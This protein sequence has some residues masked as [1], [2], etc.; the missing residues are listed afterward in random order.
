M[1]CDFV[2]MKKPCSYDL[3][4]FEDAMGIYLNKKSGEEVRK[5][6]VLYTI[7]SNS[8]EKTK[9]AQRYCDEAFNISNNKPSYPGMIYKIIKAEEEENV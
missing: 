4:G 2:L 3:N 5:G 1:Y 8:E 7:Y 6:D 9:M